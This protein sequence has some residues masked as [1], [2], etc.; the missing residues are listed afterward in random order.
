MPLIIRSFRVR[1]IACCAIFLAIFL[2]GLMPM[3]REA[4]D[5]AV[6]RFSNVRLEE[7]A[8][9][10]ITAAKVVDGELTLPDTLQDLS[11]NTVGRN[12]RLSYI[13][14]QKNNNKITAL[15]STI[16]NTATENDINF[17]TPVDKDITY[18][19]K[20]EDFDANLTDSR[21][22]KGDFRLSTDSLGRHYYVY[23]KE[24]NLGGPDLSVITMEP[25]TEYDILRTSFL[26]RFEL[27]LIIAL[28]CLLGLLAVG[29]SW[30]LKPLRR[31]G[32]Q[33]DDIEAGKREQLDE[34]VPSE[35][36]RLTKSLNRL[37]T[38]ERMQR[39]RYQ[40]T[41]G[42]LAHSLKT[43]LTVL[44][45]S[46]DELKTKDTE[47]T[48]QLAIMQTQIERMGQQIGYQ[49][50]RATQR[51]GALIGK[52]IKVRPLIDSLASTLNKVYADKQVIIT[53]EL[54]PSIEIHAEEAALLELFGNLLE[55]AYRLCLSQISL[56]GHEFQHEVLIEIADD[57]PGIPMGKRKSVLQRGVRGDSLNPGQGIGLAVV[58]DIL[59]GYNGYLEIVD[60]ALGGACF[61]IHFPL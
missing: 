39:E 31:L 29:L 35:I 42:D 33:L 22:T 45:N 6:Q 37:L 54:S 7:E 32:R 53:V 50:Q 27:W 9:A 20:V 17:N 14:T 49:L 18:A 1:L 19:K 44:Q 10:L 12:G 25:V 41:L 57:G 40:D 34:N 21:V 11:L 4:F 48:Q 13:Y 56:T 8:N 61:R 26:R 2:A 51:K 59:E 24:I 43:P 3:I 5:Q 58:Q 52:Q 60:S 23:D 38:T 28:T 55:N 15:T 46:L 30:G 47:A 16:N 36:R